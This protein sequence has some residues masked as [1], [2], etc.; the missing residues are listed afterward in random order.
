[1]FFRSR[2]EE[3]MNITPSLL[4]YYAFLIFVIYFVISLIKFLKIGEL[5]KKYKKDIEQLYEFSLGILIIY[6]IFYP[7]LFVLVTKD[8][9]FKKKE[10]DDDY[11]PN[12]FAIIGI[13]IPL[14]LC[15]SAFWLYVV[16]LILDNYF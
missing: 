14:L 5:I 16:N 6:I 12:R 10:D 4:V 9:F 7:Y 3:V 13:H 11:Q 1:M 8:A 15:W 2:I